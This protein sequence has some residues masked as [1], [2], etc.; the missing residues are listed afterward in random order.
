VPRRLQRPLRRLLAVGPLKRDVGFICVGFASL[1]YAATFSVHVTR[2]PDTAS[3]FTID[4]FGHATRLWTVPLLY[5][6]LHYD[7]LRA[8]AQT[9]IGV[10][11]WSSLAFAFAITLRHPIVAR[12]GT[13]AIVLLGLC[14]QITVWDD[15]LLSESLTISLVALLVA[16]VL[17]LRQRVT[18]AMIAASL[19][20][21]VLWTFAR[22]VN[23]ALFIGVALGLILWILTRARRWWPVAVAVAVIGAWGG[24]SVS[25]QKGYVNQ[26][27]SDILVHRILQEQDGAAFFAEAG[28]PAVDSLVRDAEKWRQTGTGAKVSPALRNPAWV[29]WA[30]RHWTTTYIRWLFHHPI[31]NIRMPVSQVPELLS[32]S[33]QLV[34]PL[35]PSGFMPYGATRLVLPSP[36]QNTLWETGS[37]AQGDLPFLIVLALVTWLVSLARPPSGH[38]VTPAIAF[39]GIAYCVVAYFAVWHLAA[40]EMARHE[41]PVA[42]AVRIFALILLFSSIDRLCSARSTRRLHTDHDG[43]DPGRTL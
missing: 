40:I 17:M 12:L 16:C 3:Y 35:C 33:V 28:M 31:K 36:I 19:A 14:V 41:L 22:Q 6:L 13:V 7:S 5:R 20:A 23:V 25:N 29:R 30:D 24:Y 34:C 27:A 15:I 42:A 39:A 26:N 37:G 9:T 32:G 2:Y 18:N 10:L 4:F 11:S 38:A 43:A 1:R 21:A 8:I